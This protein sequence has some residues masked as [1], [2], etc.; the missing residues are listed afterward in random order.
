MQH[1]A[2]PYAG[3]YQILGVWDGPVPATLQPKA[4][5]PGHR[6]SE[7]IL[8]RVEDRYILWVERTDMDRVVAALEA[9]ASVH[10]RACTSPGFCNVPPTFDLCETCRDL[11]GGSSI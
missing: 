4:W 3:L 8:A 7:A 5:E 9:E 11:M 2:G 10:R 1:R 6:T